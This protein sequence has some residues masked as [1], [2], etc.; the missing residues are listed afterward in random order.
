MKH[1]YSMI[2]DAYKCSKLYKF[3]HIDHIQPEMP[4]SSA[5]E[6]GSAMHASI[7][8]YFEGM[9]PTPVFNLYWDTIKDKDITYYHSKS[10]YQDWDYL[11]NAGEVMLSKFQ[12][13]YGNKFKV[14]HP[15]EERL[16]AKIHG[17]NFE[18]T[19]DFV[20]EF[21]GVPSI[22]DFKTSAENYTSD[23]IVCNEQMYLYA[24]L[25]KECLG[26][27]V[28]QLVYIVFVKSPP[29]IQKP[30]IQIVDPSQI[31]SQT[32]NIA[33]M[34]AELEQRRV[35][36][37]NRLSCLSK[38]KYRCSFWDYCHGDKKHD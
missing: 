30:L 21:Q 18:G 29:K 14:V 4:G 17:F 27:E 10:G 9:D 22:V 13:F 33:R 38:G 19:P 32:L 34:A 15:I 31:A 23:K 2:Q 25:A 37:Q 35:Y 7:H 11:K 26:Y 6:F 12:R 8:S 20:G 36:P 3:K 5:L 24:H 16:K 1:S 28:Q